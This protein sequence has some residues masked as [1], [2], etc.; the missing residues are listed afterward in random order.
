[1]R[2]RGCQIEVIFTNVTANGQLK[3]VGASRGGNHIIY[4]KIHEKERNGPLAAILEILLIV[5]VIVGIVAGLLQIWDRLTNGK[6]N[7]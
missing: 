6:G 1:M 7:K 3:Q 2:N 4:A 5:G